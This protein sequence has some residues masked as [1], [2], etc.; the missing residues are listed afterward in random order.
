MALYKF[1]VDQGQ[2]NGEYR[3]RMDVNPNSTVPCKIYA[4][5]DDN[6]GKEG[7]YPYPFNKTNGIPTIHNT[8]LFRHIMDDNLTDLFGKNGDD[9]E[10]DYISIN[11]QQISNKK[12]YYIAIPKISDVST[13]EKSVDDNIFKSISISRLID[14]A[15]LNNFYPLELKTKKDA[16][17]DKANDDG[18][19]NSIIT[20]VGET[21]DSSAN[22][23][24]KRF[25]LKFYADNKGEN[26]LLTVTKTPNTN[27][28]II[29]K[30]TTDERE[31]LGLHSVT[32]TS[33]II[34]YF[35]YDVEITS[36]GTKSPSSYGIR[37]CKIAVTRN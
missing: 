14:V 20:L 2:K 19:Y 30:L 4:L 15:R 17:M 21:S 24:G 1:I 18:T 25:T 32:E 10:P 37:E 26:L 35:D 13:I 12:V 8:K 29:L 28:E 36:D 23:P 6:S 3:F 7:C 22:I 27:K 11:S 31:K 34:L 33:N 9:D 5:I 16:C